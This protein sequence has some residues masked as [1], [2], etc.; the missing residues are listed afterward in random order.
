VEQV[1]IIIPVLNEAA[2]VAQAIERAWAT[3]PLEV[4]VED[5]GSD[6]GTYEI[7]AA[8]PCRALRSKQG[9]GVQQNTGAR[10]ARGSVL[11]FLHADTWLAPDGVRQIQQACRDPAVRVGCF[12]QRIEADGFA[13]RL[14]E[15]GNAFRALRLGLPYGDQGLFFRR[16]FFEELGGFPETPFMEDWQLMRRARR[17]TRPVLLPG[18]LYVSARRWQRHGIIRQ[19]LRNWML[20]TAAML[21][22]SPDRLVQFYRHER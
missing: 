11:L 2:R 19:T 7:A 6:D 15:R 13:Y 14:L 4:I 5:G 20:I 1:S 16:W 22:V 17:R 12:R 8:Q 9:R 21:G 18:P 10:Q 3:G